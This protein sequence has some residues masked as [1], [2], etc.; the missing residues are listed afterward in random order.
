MLNAEGAFRAVLAVILL[1]LAGEL[2]SSGLLARPARDG[3]GPAAFPLIGLAITAIGLAWATVSDFRRGTAAVSAS[4][5]SPFAAILMAAFAILYINAVMRVGLIASTILALPILA[6]A[7]G[8]R[9]FVQVGAVTF[10]G[11]LLIWLLFGVLL[12]VFLPRPLLF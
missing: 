7:S 9:G 12:D 2:V 3:A 1:V 4:D 8:A 6:I 10:V 5:S 11:T